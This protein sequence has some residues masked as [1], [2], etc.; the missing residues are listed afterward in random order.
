MPHESF[1]HAQKPLKGLCH[2][3]ILIYGKLAYRNKVLFP[4]FTRFWGHRKIVYNPIILFAHDG[5]ERICG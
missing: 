4:D 2:I 1:M 5:L 3:E